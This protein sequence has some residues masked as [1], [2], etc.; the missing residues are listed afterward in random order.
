M[1]PQADVTAYARLRIDNPGAT[2][3][4]ATVTVYTFP[5][6]GGEQ[7]AIHRQIQPQSQR[8]LH[9][10]IPYRIHPSQPV[11]LLEGRQG[12]AEYITKLQEVSLY[13]VHLLK[14]GRRFVT[15]EDRVNRGVGAW[16]AYNFLNVDRVDGRNRIHDG[17][18]FYENVYGYSAALYCHALSLYGFDGHAERYLKDLL[19]FQQEDGRLRTSYGTPDNGAFLFAVGQHYRLHRNDQWF[20]EMLPAAS[21]CG[22]WI[23]AARKRT[24]VAEQ[25]G[26]L[27]YGLLA[28]DD[29]PYADYPG[30][31][32]SYYVDAYCWLG[33]RELGLALGAAG[34]QDQSR[35]WL[36]EAEAYRADILASMD[37]AV[38]DLGEVRA[39]PM[40][41][42]TQRLIKQGGGDYYGLI[43]PMLLETD[44]F[45]ADYPRAD[46]I[47][48]PMEQ[49][50]GLLLGM[51]RFADGI[52][53]AYTYG[54]AITKMRAG[55]IDR[56]LLTFYG[57]LAHGMDRDTFSS[58]EVNHA[59]V[60]VND[61]TLPHTYSHTQQ[62][63]MVR[64]MLVREE[65]NDLWIAPGVPAAWLEPGKRI[66][67]KRAPTLFGKL[68][69]VLIA[70][71]NG[72]PALKIEPL[73]RNGGTLPERVRLT[74]K[75]ATGAGW[76]LALNGA[77][78]DGKARPNWS[79]DGALL[80]K[81]V[82]ITPSSGG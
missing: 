26:S 47:T 34:Q 77:G 10:R 7:V 17:G 35:R 25:K 28:S 32:Y 13:W 14:P 48:K 50:G 55:Q 20:A 5:A 66:Q 29:K 59:P 36:D 31:V 62:L 80:K 22:E 65:G 16:L 23:L 33:M 8:D 60:G 44:I 1:S 18:R 30:E 51:S 38:I 12:T 61:P 73:E 72:R 9:F 70:D 11:E 4:D 37:K 58:V 3:K 49:R 79:F 6:L 24:R 21:R 75:S 63:R 40:E 54:Y 53:H 2:L 82:R 45:D 76:Q 46:W 57:S 39:L 69:Y 81:E 64:M 67:V 41:P 43:A 71:K 68:T 19:H 42:L 56:F 52:D 78:M 15:P 74:L 27:T